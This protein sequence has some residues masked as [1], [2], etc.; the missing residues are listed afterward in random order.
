MCFLST[1]M[2]HG[3]MGVSRMSTGTLARGGV[4]L[5]S[6]MLGWRIILGIGVQRIVR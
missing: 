2:V 4:L 5:L 3:T 1:T 6:L